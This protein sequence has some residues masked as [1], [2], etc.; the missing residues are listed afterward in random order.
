MEDKMSLSESMEQT[1][2]YGNFG[3][4]GDIGEIVIDAALD[5]GILKE[6]PILGTIVGVVKCIKNTYDAFFAK[7]LIAFLIPIKDV[8]PKVRAKAIRK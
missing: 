6:I 1:I 3:F 8:S 4:V 5:D 7:K 2:E